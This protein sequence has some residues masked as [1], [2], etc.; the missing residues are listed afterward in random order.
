[1]EPRI[2]KGHIFRCKENLKGRYRKGRIYEC[3]YESLHSSGITDIY[4]CGFITND[5]GNIHHAWPY[6]PT[7]NPLAKEDD[8]WTDYFEDLG[9]K[10]ADMVITPYAV[11]D[12]VSWFCYDDYDVHKSKILSLEIKVVKNREP[13]ITYYTRIKFKGRMQDAHFTMNNIRDAIRK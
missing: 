12:T 3:E 9:E 4:S 1:M 5:V 6:F 13:I 8:R 10:P 11:G 7:L 2:I